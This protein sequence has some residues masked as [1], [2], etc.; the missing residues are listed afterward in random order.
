M[1]TNVIEVAMLTLALVLT[2]AVITLMI[3]AF[4]GV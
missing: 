2:F 1:K 3:V 4:Q